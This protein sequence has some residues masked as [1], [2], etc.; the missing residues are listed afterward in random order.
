MRRADL[1]HKPC[2]TREQF[3]DARFSRRP[4]SQL[5]SPWRTGHPLLTLQRTVGNQAVLRMLQQQPA[6]QATHVDRGASKDFRDIPASPPVGSVTAARAPVHPVPTPTTLHPKLE[7]R[8]T[9]DP[10]ERKTDCVADEA[11]R[12]RAPKVPIEPA[13]VQ[14][15]RKRAACED[16]EQKPHTESAST[17]HDPKAVGGAGVAP[18]SVEVAVT[19]RVPRTHGKRESQ[20][21]AKRAT[22]LDPKIGPGSDGQFAGIPNIP[23]EP[24]DQHIA[25]RLKTHFQADLSGVRVHTSPEAA[26]SAAD[27][28]ALAYTFGRDVYFAHGMYAPSTAEGQ[29]LLA[30]EVAHVIQQR[31]SRESAVAAG[32]SQGV[33][34]GAPDD[35]LETEAEEKADEF[36][37]SAPVPRED[38]RT[39]RE[40]APPHVQRIV[41]R[42]PAP[43]SGGGAVD[44]SKADAIKKE[45]DSFWP[46]NSKLEEL[47][48]SLGAGLPEAI[49]D[50]AYRD[51]WWRSVNDEKISLT[52]A[53]RPLLRAFATDVVSVAR[54]R[55]SS[56]VTRLDNLQN[57]LKRASGKKTSV[58]PP[59]QSS[60]GGVEDPQKQMSVSTAP[61]PI[62]DARALVDS[63]TVLHF[64]RT[65]D[66]LLKSS[67]VGM[68]R[69]DTSGLL[70]S[71]GA[72]PTPV[73]FNP[74][75][76][77]PLPQGSGGVGGAGATPAAAASGQPILYD[78]NISLDAL[79][80]LPNVEYIDLEAYRALEKTYRQ[81]S[82]QKGMF[83]ELAQEML[84]E[85]ANLAVL[86][87]K[88]LVG[89][90]SALSRSTDAEASATIARVATENADSAHHFLEMLGTAGTVDWKALRP[91][92]AYLLAGGSGGSRNWSNIT[93]K[94]FVDNYFQEVAEA[95]RA[96][97]Q[98]ELVAQLALTAAT[99]VAL[100]TP[101]APLAS[102]FLLATDALAVGSAVAQSGAAEKKADVLSA[103]AD[104]GVVS[105]ED[106]AR[107]RQEAEEK[108]ASMVMTILLTALPYMPRVA[109]AGAAAA[110]AIGREITWAKL[111]EYSSSR[112]MSGAAGADFVLDLAKVGVSEFARTLV[113]GELS[114]NRIAARIPAHSRTLGWISV[115][116]ALEREGAEDLLHAGSE[117]G[118]KNYIRYHIHG[119]G[120]GAERFPIFL[121]PTKANQYANN[122]IEGYMRKQRDL[123]ASV[124]FRA[125]YTTYNGEELR[126]FI[127]N[128]LR[129]GDK[130]VIERLA[131][132]QGRIET[133]LKEITYDVEVIPVSG[134]AKNRIRATISIDPPP[135]GAVAGGPLTIIG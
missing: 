126:P 31:S 8:A 44:T 55:L 22:S 11:M 125:T 9:R 79:L 117:Y 132:D 20:Q 119:P 75:P 94:G 36:T 84:E 4:Q 50:K 101:A 74:F 110:S 120:T 16:D 133:F 83:N 116:E 65:W 63:A 88:G 21:I 109:G 45:L 2:S 17:L 123:G 134:G 18:G 130:E 99:F 90:V 98:A 27:L 70:P 127:E 51:L 46:S 49:N 100:L 85:D 87:E 29:H 72:P 124:R 28:N 69:V 112:L 113:G 15:S 3:K 54:E 58:Q 78:P 114:L 26:E 73:P 106:A 43:E 89:Q 19:R 128:L 95:E 38:E 57:E 53:A 93:A 47:W 59:S 121:A 52:A 129:S 77:S 115:T 12:V 81:C 41:Q 135:G 67:A 66:S 104:A 35:V 5:P 102:F 10:L 86:D 68:R 34:V 62:V 25:K 32:L 111:A 1:N 122:T 30:H 105:K 80:A 107:A 42:Q 37:S 82:E 7:V 14:V 97:A 108:H 71:P 13:P 56:Q 24:L 118:L 33:K 48:A 61:K 76:N 6:E 131:R 40:A 23:G 92:H 39:K 103:G 91:I 60:V 64:L 96:K